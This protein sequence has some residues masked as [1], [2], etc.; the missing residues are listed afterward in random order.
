MNLK[1]ILFI[2]IETV[3]QTATFEELP[4][5]LQPLWEKKAQY[6]SEKTVSTQESFSDKAAIY[7]EFGRIIVIGL[8]Y[9]FYNAENELSLKLKSISGHNEQ[10]VLT[11]FIQLLTHKFD[12][13]TTLLCAH[14]GKEF[15]FPYLCRRMLINEIPLP[16]I[17]Q[18]SHKKP[19][20]INHIDTMELWK[21]GDKKSYT[22]LE[23]LA[24]VFDIPAS[25]NDLSGDK[26]NQAY[27]QENG[28]ERIATYCQKDVAVLAQL[29]LKLNGL[30]GIK[31]ENILFV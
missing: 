8:G 26:V 28:L 29:Y 16:E 30:Q 18:I 9:L 11:D 3:A 10:K 15:D 14:N 2:D 23:L 5:R 24:A 17:L 22:S 21:F 20:E 31:P 7:A 4:E 1:N 27:Y 19:W 13:K 6:I 12:P 25:K